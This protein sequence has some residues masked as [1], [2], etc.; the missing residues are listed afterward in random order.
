MPI[1]VGQHVFLCTVSSRKIVKTLKHMYVFIYSYRST[2]KYIYFVRSSLVSTLEARKNYRITNYNV[3][4]THLVGESPS[5]LTSIFKSLLW[6]WFFVALGTKI[7]DC[8][9]SVC[10]CYISP[11][12]CS[13]FL[14]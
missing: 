5:R 3:N 9:H 13:P 11:V 8:H 2:H 1:L 7:Q 6:H 4:V 12:I 14:N 10:L